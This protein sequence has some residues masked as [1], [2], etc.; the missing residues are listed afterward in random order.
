MKTTILSLFMAV[1]LLGSFNVHAIPPVPPTAASES[2]F[3]EESE[4]VICKDLNALSVEE[5]DYLDAHED[6]IVSVYLDIRFICY[7]KDL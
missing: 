6:S 3:E 7:N 1:M 2:I 5:I 4:S